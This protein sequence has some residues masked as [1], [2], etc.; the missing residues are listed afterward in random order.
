MRRTQDDI[1]A[2]ILRLV[3]ERGLVGKTAIVYGVNLNFKIVNPYIKR[4]VERG[5]LKKEEEWG[6]HPKYRTGP[7]AEVFVDTLE[8]LRAI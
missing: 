2:D 6:P 5:L 7:M 8:M 1:E 3:Q 4:L